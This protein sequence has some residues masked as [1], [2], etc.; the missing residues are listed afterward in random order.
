M[1]TARME[2]HMRTITIL[3]LLCLTSAANAQDTARR[4]ELP[5]SSF[6]LVPSDPQIGFK[7]FG[8]E[9]GPLRSEGHF[10]LVNLTGKPITRILILVEFLDQQDQHVIGIPFY[11]GAVTGQER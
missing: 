2:I 5:S 8:A 1:R 11:A 9:I 4:C 7:R 6:S 3:V 10:V